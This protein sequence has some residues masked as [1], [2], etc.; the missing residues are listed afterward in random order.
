MGSTEGEI[1]LAS[2]VTA[3]ACALAG[4]IVNPLEYI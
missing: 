3:A 1:Y 4:K 2:P